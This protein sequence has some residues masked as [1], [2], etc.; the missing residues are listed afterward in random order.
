MGVH[1]MFT[2]HIVYPYQ[3][4]TISTNMVAS[5]FVTLRNPSSQGKLEER[6][7]TY[8]DP[9]CGGAIPYTPC[10]CSGI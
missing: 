5:V 6:I 9:L 4:H 7:A 2:E 10:Q 8:R 3:V 1:K